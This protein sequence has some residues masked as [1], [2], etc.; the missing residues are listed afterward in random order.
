MTSGPTPLVSEVTIVPADDP[1][2]ASWFLGARLSAHPI[3]SVEEL[4]GVV[5][6]RVVGTRARVARAE[7]ELARQLARELADY[8]EATDRALV[9]NAEAIRLAVGLPDD[10]ELLVGRL[11][12]YGQQLRA[13]SSLLSEA[14]VAVVEAERRLQDLAP[15]TSLTTDVELLR[16][17][18]QDIALAEATAQNAQREL[19]TAAKA[20]RPEQRIELREAGK[21][22]YQTGLHFKQALR[23][24]KPLLLAAVALFAVAAA[25][26]GAAAVGAVSTSAAAV[27]GGVVCVLALGALVQRRS[28]VRPARRACVAAE[29]DVQ[30]LGT[31]LRD[32]EEQF[33]D[34][35]VRVME[36]MSADDA[37]RAALERW[38]AV[39]G[40]DVDPQQVEQ[41]AAAVSSLDQARTLRQRAG[42]EQ[43]SCEAE[44]SRTA[45][46]LGI[47]TEPLPEPAGTVELAERALARR[48]VATE[49]LRQLHDAE[50]RQGARMRL[51]E[52]LRGRT[53]TQLE[54]DAQSLTVEAGGDGD[55]DHPLL[56]V[57]Q[58]TIGPDERVDLLQEARRLGPE[59]RFVV[60]TRDPSEWNVA[61]AA[62]R[63]AHDETDAERTSVE[64]DLREPEA[65]AEPQADDRR[66]WFA[67]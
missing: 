14:D 65:T 6:Q 2:R 43:S 64:I 48:D 28:V 27:L 53:L 66:P 47:S 10:A 17:T 57:D 5:D 23:E 34:W 26:G 54:A 11:R 67:S 33:G 20:V 51:A 12:Q 37:L 58:D 38:E 35:G 39:A 63:R 13:A 18:S 44:W 22:A 45:E 8:D 19:G 41:L 7:A 3:T 9:E 59:G 29:A 30:M 52:I 36:S 50:R 60:V 49:Q 15:G 55:R 46:S 16:E 1:A 61:S 25:A 56:Y 31:Q 24:T 42:E 32:Q 40:Q 21:R 4:R 62:V